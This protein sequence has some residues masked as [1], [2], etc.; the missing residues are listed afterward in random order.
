M[1]SR[2]SRPQAAPPADLDLPCMPP[3]RPILERLDEPLPDGVEF[4]IFA[5]QPCI[6]FVDWD[7]AED[8]SGEF[9]RVI[10]SDS[11]SGA[12]RTQ[13]SEFWALVRRGRG[14]SG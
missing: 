7:Y 11:L 14:L 1:P 4:C 9:V 6:L 8:W 5:G 3:D 10:P 2:E 13:A 12:P